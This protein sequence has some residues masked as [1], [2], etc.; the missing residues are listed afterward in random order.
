LQIPSTISDCGG[1][2]PD[3]AAQVIPRSRTL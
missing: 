2:L 3:F 1:S